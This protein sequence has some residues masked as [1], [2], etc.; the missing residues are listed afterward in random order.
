[1]KMYRQ[2]IFF[3]G[4]ILTEG[5][6]YLSTNA[7]ILVCYEELSFHEH[8]SAVG[9]DSSVSIVTYYGLGGLEIESW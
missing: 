6:C 7:G 8:S 3:C 9:Q 2:V 1:M 5:V 4:N